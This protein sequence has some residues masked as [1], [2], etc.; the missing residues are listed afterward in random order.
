MEQHT[1]KWPCGRRRFVKVL[2]HFF[3]A[4]PRFRFGSEGLLYS[5][6][7]KL[8]SVLV[9]LAQLSRVVIY[10]LCP[11]VVLYKYTTSFCKFLIVAHD[12]ISLAQRYVHDFRPSGIVGRCCGLLWREHVDRKLFTVFALIRAAR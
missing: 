10:T 2:P 5:T 3:A 1:V 9:R 4:G 7:S 8:E 11:T 6:T 12:T